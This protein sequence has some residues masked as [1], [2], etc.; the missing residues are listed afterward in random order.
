MYVTTK[1]AQSPAAR[2]TTAWTVND[3]LRAHPATVAVF[4]AFRVD[5]CCGG[6]ASLTEAALHAHVDPETLMAA[7]E[8]ILDAT[9]AAPRAGDSSAHRREEVA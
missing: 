7:L 8:A 4:N 6:T 9:D 1:R 5:A 3:V 2:I